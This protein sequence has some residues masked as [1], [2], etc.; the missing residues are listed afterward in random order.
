MT[1]SVFE[2]EGLYCE[3]NLSPVDQFP[4]VRGRRCTDRPL[5]GA[6]ENR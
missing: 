1:V 3:N 2:L 6:L 4:S 5:S